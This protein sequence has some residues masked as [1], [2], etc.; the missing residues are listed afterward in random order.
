MSKFKLFFFT[1]IG[2]GVDWAINMKTGVNLDDP[3]V[4]VTPIFNALNSAT[5]NG[6]YNTAYDLQS[7]ITSQLTYVSVIIQLFPIVPLIAAFVTNDV[8][9]NSIAYIE[10][11]L[12]GFVITYLLL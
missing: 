10:G 1:G 4:Y 2:F 9:R 11:I 3:T 8:K 5:G 12:I 6:P 7:Q